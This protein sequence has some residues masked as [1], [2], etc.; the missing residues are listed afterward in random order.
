M[1][2]CLLLL[3][4][5]FVTGCARGPG[6]GE[7]CAGWQPIRPEA[8]DAGVISASLARQILAHDLHGA[9]LCGWHP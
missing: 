7:P 5:L 9:A 1:T 3:T 8:S 6:P 2:R 4:A